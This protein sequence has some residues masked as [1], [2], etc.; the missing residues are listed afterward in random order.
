MNMIDIPTSNGISNW[1]KRIG[2]DLIL[3]RLDRFL[4]FWDLTTLNHS[5]FAKILPISRSNHFLIRLCIAEVSKSR[6][7][8]FKC[9]NMWFHD[10]KFLFLLEIWWN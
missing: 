1:N 6:R 3:E 2:S 10:P 5:F 7:I 4:Y 8:P 9:E